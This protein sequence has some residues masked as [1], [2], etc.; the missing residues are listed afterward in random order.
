VLQEFEE[1]LAQ[2]LN[3]H[4]EKGVLKEEVNK[5]KRGQT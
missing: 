3:Y 5:E 2:E 4:L 1:G